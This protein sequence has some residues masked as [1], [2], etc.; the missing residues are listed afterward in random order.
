[1]S[2]LHLLARSLTKEW[3]FVILLCLLTVNI[4][5]LY[6]I[7]YALNV[8]IQE[9]RTGYVDAVVRLTTFGMDAKVMP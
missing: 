4:F 3:L 2:F 5:I 7:C 9:L 1:M 6:G 8:S